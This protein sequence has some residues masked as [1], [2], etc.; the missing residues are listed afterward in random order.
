ML[1]LTPT[2]SILNSQSINHIRILVVSIQKKSTHAMQIPLRQWKTTKTETNYS[3]QRTVLLVVH[4][5]V[6]LQANL[7]N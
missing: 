4:F 5:I 6:V 2:H 3:P 7:S 1:M